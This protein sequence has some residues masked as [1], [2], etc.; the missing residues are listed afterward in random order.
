MDARHLAAALGAALLAGIAPG[1]AFAGDPIMPLSELRPGMQCTGYSVIRGTEISA[2]DVEIVDVVSGDASANDGPRILIRVSGE[3]VDRTGV[4]PGFSGS[5]VYCGGRNA[6]AISEAIGEYG[7]KTVLATP[8]EEI[9]SNPP[10]APRGKPIARRARIGRVLPLAEPLTVSGLNR[11]LARKLTEA[12]AK[13]HRQVLAAPAMPL[14]PFPPSP[15][16]PGSAMSVGYSSGDLAVGAVGTVAYVDGDRV[17]GFGHPFENSGL[18]ALLLQDAYVYTVISNPNAGDDTGST[19]KLAAVGHTLGTISNDASAAVVGRSGPTPPTVPVRIFSH[20]VDT[21]EQST[22]SS[23]VVDETDAGTPT[24]GAALTFVAPLALAQGASA[25]LR[26]APGKLSGTVCLQI[27]LRERK[28]PIR[29][30]NRYVSAIAPSDPEAG[31]NIVA[32]GGASDALAALTE[33]DDYKPR[34]LH[35]TEFAARVKLHRGLRQAFLRKVELPRRVR[36]G[37]RVARE[38]PPPGR[39]RA[40]YH[41]HV[42]P[43]HPERRRPRAPPAHV[44]RPRRRRPG[45]RPVRR[46]RRHDHHRRR[47]GGGRLR[48]RG[49]AHARRARPADQ[50]PAALRRRAPALRRHP[51]ARLSRP[52]APDLRPCV[53]GRARHAQ[54]PLTR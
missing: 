34:A 1:T 48:A 9:L 53:D 8:I 24:G 21:G 41:A 35:V 14:S 6:G 28:Q 13:A 38:A 45:L 30:C 19:Y 15:P 18:R 46:A 54:A 32:A 17:W 29:L 50:G 33:I 51:H 20:D 37:R 47:R 23:R 2:F 16:R 3:A 44:R 22:L 40:A 31:A 52:G 43:A 7:G 10:D 5:P 27:R 25:I 12:G 36:P 49:R 42:P 4:G 11:G 39:A 26:S